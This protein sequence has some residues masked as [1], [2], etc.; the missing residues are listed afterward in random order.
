MPQ[1]IFRDRK[2]P[3]MPS[4]RTATDEYKTDAPPIDSTRKPNSALKA[5]TTRMVK[6]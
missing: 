3:A 5:T 2:N 4:A 6:I 1:A